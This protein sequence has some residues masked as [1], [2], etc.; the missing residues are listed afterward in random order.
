MGTDSGPG[1]NAA[2]FIGNVIISGAD[3][4]IGAGNLILLTGNGTTWFRL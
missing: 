2:I 1:L 3:I 4:G